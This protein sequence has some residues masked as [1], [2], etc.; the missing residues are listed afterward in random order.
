MSFKE[1]TV[2]HGFVAAMDYYVHFLTNKGFGPL[3]E[4]PA[5]Y[6]LKK[7]NSIFGDRNFRYPYQRLFQRIAEELDD[8]RLNSRVVNIVDQVSGA[9]KRVA[10][11]GAENVMCSQV[12][13]AYPPTKDSV[14]FISVP[15]DTREFFGAVKTFNYGYLVIRDVFLSPCQQGHCIES[16]IHRMQPTNLTNP[17]AEIVRQSNS[18]DSVAVVMYQYPGQSKEDVIENMVEFVGKLDE[19]LYDEEDVVEA[20]FFPNFP[21]VTENIEEFHSKLKEIQGVNGMYYI[22]SVWVVDVVEAAVVSAKVVVEEYFQ[23]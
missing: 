18:V 21:H 2:E 6:A 22:G 1:H 3:D 15:K 11:R 17:P 23:D 20:H 13:L 8:V 9:Y 14:N 16:F 19:A 12:V 5:I 7:F 10:I 4:I